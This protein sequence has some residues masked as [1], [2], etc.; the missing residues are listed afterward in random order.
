M[1]YRQYRLPQT[2]PQDEPNLPN[3]FTPN[4]DGTNDVFSFTLKNGTV[5]TFAVYNRWGNLVAEVLE[6]TKLTGAAWDGYTTAGEPCND[7]VYF[8]VLEYTDAKGEL[9]TKRD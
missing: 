9:K 2:P 8:Y 1:L 7:G 3:V 4:G 5:K 6:A